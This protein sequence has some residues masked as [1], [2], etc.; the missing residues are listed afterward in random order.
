MEAVGSSVKSWVE[1]DN[2]E[3]ALRLRIA[4]IKKLKTEMNGSI[5]TFMRE[6][7]VDNF[8]LEE[9]GS[10][11]RSTR[12]TRPPLKRSELRTQLL[13]F[14]PDQQDKVVEFLKFIEGEPT[15]KEVIT[16]RVPRKKA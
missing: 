13:L 16:R 2:E 10:M 12:T 4:E 14:F 6:N 11:T 15:Q 1:L 9:S 3:K 5:L 7:E 8:N